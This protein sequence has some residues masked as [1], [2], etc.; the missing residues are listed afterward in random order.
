MGHE[1]YTSVVYI[2]VTMNRD[3]H[4]SM[5]K[6]LKKGSLFLEGVIKHDASK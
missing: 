6:N 5:S 1:K 3:D 4:I 2:C